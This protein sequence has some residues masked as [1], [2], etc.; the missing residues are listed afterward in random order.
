VR[1]YKVELDLNNEQRTA[2]LQHAGAARWAYNFGLRRKREAYAAGQKTPTA[3]DLHRELCVLKK[4]D[5]PWLYS[6]SKCAPQ[7]ALRNLDRAFAHFFRRCKQGAKKKGYPKFKSRKRGIG[8]FM[9]EGAVRATSRTITLPRIGEVRLKECDYIPS[10]SPIKSVVVSERAGHWFVAARTDED[11]PA[12]PSG[13][14]TLGVDVG[15]VHLATLSDGTVFE[16]PKALRKAQHLLRQRQKAVSRKVKGSANRRKA[17][18]RL[19]RQHYRV[20]CVRND[21]IHKATTAIAKRAVVLGIESLNVAGM[22]KN[23]R[24][25]GALADADLSEFHRQLD[26]KTKWHGGTVVKADRFFPSSKKCSSCG[27]VKAALPLSERVFR[28]ECGNVVDRDENAAINL[29]NLAVSSTATACCPGGSGQIA[30]GLVKPLAG[31]EPN[32]AQD[33]VLNG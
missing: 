9:L 22:M 8:S 1:S 28:C 4:T 32:T 23:H 6:V 15:I 12:R 27:R 10:G 5:V 11:M 21:A 7:Q 2:C 18:Q 19:A 13:G 33:V 30:V 16:N 31:Q 3:I 14:E 29:K 25:A 26:Y 20:T 17:V 24:L